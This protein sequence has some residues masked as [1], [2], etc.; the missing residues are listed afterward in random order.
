MYREFI[1]GNKKF[2]GKDVRLWKLIK[3]VDEIEKR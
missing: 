2:K 3:I 1:M